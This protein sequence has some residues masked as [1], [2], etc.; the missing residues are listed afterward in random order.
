M[1]Y[2][3]LINGYTWYTN[4]LT[5]SPKIQLSE[6][7]GGVLT[8]GCYTKTEISQIKQQL[9]DFLIL[10]FN[11]RLIHLNRSGIFNN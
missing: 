9:N 4:T 10:G 3:I 7:V 5:Y 2:E 6:S 8:E 1:W 11:T